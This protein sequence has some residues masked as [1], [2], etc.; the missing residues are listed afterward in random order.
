MF[1]LFCNLL[2]LWIW[3]FLAPHVNGILRCVSGLFHLAC[4]QV[5]VVACIRISFLFKVNNISL[6]VYT[7]FVCG[8][9]S[10]CCF[11]IVK[12]SCVNCL[13]LEI[14]WIYVKCLSSCLTIQASINVWC[15]SL[16]LFLLLLL[17]LMLTSRV[18][19]REVQ[20]AHTVTVPS[21]SRVFSAQ[22]RSLV[23]LLTSLPRRI[24]LASSMQEGRGSCLVGCGEGAT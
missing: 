11:F 3:L 20:S 19:G 22:P 1:T 15:C 17:L 4:F 14:K 21:L 6:W 12:I 7:I 16:L 13:K 10:F 8:H 9:L 24:H 2:F 23:S 18:T 5:H